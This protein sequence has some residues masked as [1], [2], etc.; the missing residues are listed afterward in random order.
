MLGHRLDLHD[1]YRL[2][3][4]YYLDQVRLTHLV[5]PRSHVKWV[6]DEVYIFPP[7][8]TLDIFPERFFKFVLNEAFNVHLKHMRRLLPAVLE[9]H[10]VFLFS[11][12]LGS[13]AT[14][15]LRTRKSSASTLGSAA[16]SERQSA[17]MDGIRIAPG[18]P[19]TRT[20]ATPLC[21][22]NSSTWT[23]L[24]PT[25]T[26]PR[27]RRRSTTTPTRWHRLCRPQTLT[28]PSDP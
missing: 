24:S 18:S 26:F 22:T 27:R 9:F 25:S 11:R 15:P 3:D 7:L 12:C 28:P 2:S 21:G 14:S 4:H 8:I 1:P 16:G 5:V 19:A 17:T 10:S 23:N 6:K 13:P 20:T